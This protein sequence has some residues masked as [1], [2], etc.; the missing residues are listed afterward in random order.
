MDHLTFAQLLG[1]YGEFIG[2]IAVLATLIYLALQTR[3]TGRS[4][5]FAAVQAYRAERMAWFQSNRDSPYM[6]KI[7]VKAETGQSLDAEEEYRLRSHNSALWGSVYSQWLQHE[8]ALTGRYATKDASMIS[9][10]IS[11]PRALEWWERKGA[12]PYPDE[13]CEY[14][15]QRPPEVKARTTDDSVY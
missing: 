12:S 7:F 2:S 4:T 9:M 1:S 10:A 11:T 3:Q 15:I 5:T 6:P 8:L 13:F 14:V